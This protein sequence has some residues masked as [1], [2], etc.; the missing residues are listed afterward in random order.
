MSFT[1]FMLDVITNTF[2]PARITIEDGKYKE[3]TPIFVDEDTVLD[4][5]GLMMPGF[6]DS[7]IHIES[8]MMT[9]AQFAKVAVRHGTTGV[10]CDPHE[11]ANVLGIEGIEAMI[12]NAKKVPFNF[13]FSAPSCVPAT[14]FETAGAVI[15][16]SDINYLLKKDEIVALGEMMNFPGVINGDEEV[17]N[18]LKLARIHNKPID[19]HAPLLSGEN[20]NKYLKQQISTDHE[21]SNIQEAFEKKM[22]GMKIMV[23]DGS[24]AV[25]MENLFNIEDIYSYVEDPKRFG[26]IFRDIFEKKIYA[27]LFDF[28]V[29]DDKNPND[30][31]EGHLNKSVKKAYELGIDILNAIN[32]VTINPAYHYNLNCGAIVVGANAD[33]IIVDSIHDLNILETYIGGECVF[34]GKNVLFDAPEVEGRNSI[35]ATKKSASDFDILYDG[36]ECEVNVIECIDGDL[37]TKKAT[38]KLKTKEGV[39][40]PDIIQ[41]VLKISVVERYGGNKVSNAFIKGFGLKKGA[42]ASSVAHDSHNIIVVGY[43]SEMMAKAV[44]EVID[45]HGGISV[46]SEDFSDSLPLPIAGLMSNEDAEVVAEKLTVLHNMV[47]A[48]GS[49]LKSPFMTMAFMALLVIPSIKISDMGLFDGDAFEFIDVIRD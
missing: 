46:V 24:S 18:K 35:N 16:S 6:I 9:P 43:N 32:M 8:S 17:L 31:L 4:M 36:D 10:V 13:F 41:D 23:R 48:L 26:V 39:V 49:N 29:S 14:P 44:N 38:A 33:F 40:Q 20:L 3:I 22:K 45:N 21:C 15:D 5:P 47:S 7:H 11:I 25:D 42:I 30:L 1:A 28:I 37:L 34:D 19:G 2:Y 27:P 12:D